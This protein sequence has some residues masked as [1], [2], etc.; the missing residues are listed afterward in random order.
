M[1]GIPTVVDRLIQQALNQVLTLIFDPDFS[2]YSYGFSAGKKGHDVVRQA[3]DYIQ[4]CYKAANN[5]SA[6]YSRKGKAQIKKCV[7]RNYS[8]YDYKQYNIEYR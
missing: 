6:A 1:L 3:R 5:C 8:D 4:Q 7:S 2:Q